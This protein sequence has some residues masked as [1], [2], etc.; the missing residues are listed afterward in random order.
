MKREI[1]VGIYK[2]TNKVN[3]KSYIGQSV[4]I[5]KRWVQHL[6]DVVKN[7]VNN[8][9]LIHKSIRKYGVKQFDF[10]I[11]WT[12]EKDLLN[13]MEIYFIKE[14]N[15]IKPYGY[16]MNTGGDCSISG[17]LNPKYDHTLYTFYNVDGREII[18]TKFNFREE[19]NISESG[20]YKLFSGRF[21]C[22]KGWSLTKENNSLFNKF[23]PRSNTKYSFINN[24][25]I[26]EYDITQ[27][28]LK[29]KYTY[30]SASHLSSVCCAVR[31]SVNG[32]KL[33]NYNK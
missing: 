3:E 14:L 29:K 11:L 22:Y 20:L 26:I 10:S 7:D 5:L 25:G 8:N 24:E 27:N 32:W 16:N 4:N 15:T 9:S 23:K 17:A 33:Y 6:N 30:I 31:G 28:E 13:E 2:I 21:K 19:H 18:S 12:G 1:I